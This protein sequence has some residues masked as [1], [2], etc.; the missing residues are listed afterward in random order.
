[1]LITDMNV[2]SM[3]FHNRA[4]IDAACQDSVMMVL[5]FLLLWCYIIVLSPIH[6][7]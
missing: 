2:C 5:L 4:M 1:M 3:A 6:E 7:H